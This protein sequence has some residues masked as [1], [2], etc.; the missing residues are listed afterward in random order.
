MR[1]IVIEDELELA[2][3]LAKRLKNEG[4]GVDVCDNGLDAEDYIKSSSYDLILLDIMLPKTRWLY[5][6]KED[7]KAEYYDTGTVADSKRFHR[8]SC[9]GI[10]YGSK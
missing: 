1:I 3:I 10:G 8:G 6:A 9:K 4:Y 2:N 5:F 7:T